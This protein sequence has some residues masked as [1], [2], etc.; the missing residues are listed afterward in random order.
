M[1][2]QAARQV[3]PDTFPADMEATDVEPGVTKR[4]SSYWRDLAFSRLFP[5]LFFSVFLARQLLFVWG[6]LT[7]LPRPGD[8]PFLPQQGPAL[9][10]FTILVLLYSARL[11]NP[12]TDP[13]PCRA[14]IAFTRT[15]S[16]L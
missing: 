12:G 10:Y 6:G 9:A 8:Y 14:F 15:F 3:R 1:T 2:F 4:D 5:A 16:P 11:P 13:R 7:S